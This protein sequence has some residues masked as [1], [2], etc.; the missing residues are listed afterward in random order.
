MKKVEKLETKVKYAAFGKTRSH[1][2]PRILSEDKPGKKCDCA[3]NKVDNELTRCVACIENEERN[4][5]IVA[6]QSEKMGKQIIEVK[7]SR[8]GRVGQVFKMKSNILGHKKGGTEP[9]AIKDPVTGELFV[10]NE[11][12][13]TKV[14][15]G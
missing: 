9:H 4:M 6:R 8:K 12:G 2:F 14:L 10:A 13:N 3:T 11:E 7:E 15:C 1:N 5:N